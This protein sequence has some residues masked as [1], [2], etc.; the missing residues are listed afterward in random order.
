M[1]ATHS[2][3]RRTRTRRPVRSR[4]QH[5]LPQLGWWWLGITVIGMGIAKTW[6]ALT[7]TAITLTGTLFILRAVRPRRI[8][9]ILE[10]ISL[11]TI[12]RPAL[13]ARG[14]RT[15]AAFQR[16]TPARFEHAIAELAR[17]DP[18]VL[19]ALAV[20]QANDRG[21]DVHVHLTNGQRILVQCKKYAPGNN[22]GSDVIQT[23]N[24][25]YRDIHHCHQAVIVTTA[26]FTRAAVQTNTMLPQPIRL[27]DGPGLLAWANGGPAP[28]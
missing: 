15:L 4:R 1:A 6:P 23:I 20:G 18:D 13:P 26:G 10:R 8:T 3:A 27:I 22:I 19:Q 21:M 14:H 9:R 7:I 2:T 16:M 28:W 12:R 11:P 25:V 24:G 5:R 17:K